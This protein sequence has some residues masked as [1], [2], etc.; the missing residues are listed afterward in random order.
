MAWLRGGLWSVSELRVEVGGWRLGVSPGRSSAAGGKLCLHYLKPATFEL[1]NHGTLAQKEFSTHS[2]YEMFSHIIFFFSLPVNMPLWRC[3]KKIW[4][5]QLPLALFH[6]ISMCRQGDVCYSL[7]LIS[8][9]RFYRCAVY[10]W[11]ISFSFHFSFQQILVCNWKSPH[12]VSCRMVLYL[13]VREWDKTSGTQDNLSQPA[14]S[15]GSCPMLQTMSS[16]CQPLCHCLIRKTV[17]FH[18]VLHLC[19]RSH[20]LCNKLHGLN[21]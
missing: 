12:W 3:S 4:I 20:H 10:K 19:K 11:C 15:W 17:L 9:N 18:S 1:M 5:T 6:H 13:N 2:L 8:P 14:D 21:K 7:S 16:C